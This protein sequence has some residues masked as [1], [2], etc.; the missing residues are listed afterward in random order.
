VL[1]N[2]LIQ[3][4]AFAAHRAGEIDACLLHLQDGKPYNHFTFLIRQ[5]ESTII[6]GVSPTP[7][8]R[9]LLAGGL[10][11]YAMRSRHQGHIRLETPDLAIAYTAPDVTPDTGLGH[12]LEWGSR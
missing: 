10:T 7:L 11:D 2:G 9:T 12:P 3:T 1:L 5:I 8:E 4:F 6:N